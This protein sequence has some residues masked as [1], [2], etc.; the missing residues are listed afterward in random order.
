GIQWGIDLGAGTQDMGAFQGYGAL[1]REAGLLVNYNLIM[2]GG[3]QVNALGERF[4]NELEDISG[5]SQKVL[6]QEGGVAWVIW[7]ERLHRSNSRWHEYQQLTA[8][9]MTRSAPTAAELAEKLG[10]PGDLLEATIRQVHDSTSGR[11]PDPFGRDFGPYPPLAP[12]FYGTKVTGALFH[13][14]GGLVV[15]GHA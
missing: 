15:D 3:I 12:P 9:N 13:T 6:A 11:L 5:Q 1:S 7:D 10:L 14:Q 4:S 8:L 2:E